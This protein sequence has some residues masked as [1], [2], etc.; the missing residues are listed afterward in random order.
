MKE[1]PHTSLMLISVALFCKKKKKMNLNHT[2]M[3]FTCI[4]HCKKFGQNF[5]LSVRDVIYILN[6]RF[7]FYSKCNYFN[8]SIF[9]PQMLFL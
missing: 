5:E 8:W 6:A 2:F 1:K 4:F 7:N 3:S 9:F